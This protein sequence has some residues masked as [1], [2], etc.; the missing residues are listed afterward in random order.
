MLTLYAAFIGE[1]HRVPVQYEIIVE[2]IVNKRSL[3]ANGSLFLGSP[4][5][6]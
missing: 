6:L 2:I 3:I 4:F 1:M 5:L